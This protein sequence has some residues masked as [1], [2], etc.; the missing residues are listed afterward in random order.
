MI[1]L[2]QIHV[3]KKLAKIKNCLYLLPNSTRT[4][5]VKSHIAETAVTVFSC[6]YT[7]HY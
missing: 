2:N 1:A 3:K 6:T 4:N 7:Y 5:Y